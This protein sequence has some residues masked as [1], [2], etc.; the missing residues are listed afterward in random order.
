MHGAGTQVGTDKMALEK[1][2]KL[3]WLPTGSK[4]IK[5]GAG[6]I[7]GHSMALPRH[8]LPRMPSLDAVLQGKSCTKRGG[9]IHPISRE[10]QDARHRQDGHNVPGWQSH[11]QL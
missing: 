3:L 4:N 2:S 11:W 8:P 7:R 1:V 10:F 9:K 5:R 6:G